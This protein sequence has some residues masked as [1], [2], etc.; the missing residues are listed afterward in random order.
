MADMD[1][2]HPDRGGISGQPLVYL[3]GDWRMEGKY[4]VKTWTGI[5]SEI[6]LQDHHR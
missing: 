2:L 3:I 5:L 1:Y 6:F 4:W